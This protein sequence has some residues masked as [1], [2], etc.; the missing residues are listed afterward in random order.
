MHQSKQP[1]ARGGQYSHLPLT[2][3]LCFPIDQVPN[4]NKSFL[5]CCLSLS[6]W[7]YLDDNNSRKLP[8]RALEEDFRILFEVFVLFGITD[9]EYDRR[10]ELFPREDSV[11]GNFDAFYVSEPCL[12]DISDKEQGLTYTPS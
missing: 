1:L 6:D 10:A 12:L 7:L 5:N 9:F 8:L 4:F 2:S 11:I 3:L